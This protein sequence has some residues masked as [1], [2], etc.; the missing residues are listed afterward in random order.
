MKF[1]SIGSDPELFLEKDGKI[2]SAIGLIGG[3]K[4]KPKS[5]KIQGYYVQEDNVLVEFNTPPVSTR[6]EFINAIRTGKALVADELD[7]GYKLVIQSSHVMDPDQL[8]KKKAKRF[9]CDPDNNAWTG[10]LQLP[11]PPNDGLRTAGGHV[12]VGYENP[13]CELNVKIAKALDI[14]LGLESVMLDNDSRR[15]ELYGAAGSFR[16]KSFGMEYRTLSSFW[17]AKPS[18]I[19]WVYDGVQKALKFVAE[20]GIDKLEPIDAVYIQVAINTSDLSIAYSLI[21]KFNVKGYGK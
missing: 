19:A 4:K 14:F 18:T 17:I 15:R 3:T 21:E 9:G 13:T 2:V 20:G 5:L 10:E 16:H 7:G 12:Y 1:L 6:D 8:T 11:S